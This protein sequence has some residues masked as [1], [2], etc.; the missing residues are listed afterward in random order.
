ME[1]I[2]MRKV[3]VSLCEDVLLELDRAARESQ[4]TRSVFLAQA[5]RYYL[6]ELEEERRLGFRH[7]E[8]PT[9]RDEAIRTTATKDG[10][11]RPSREGLAMTGFSI[12]GKNQLYYLKDF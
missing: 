6:K 12:E 11:L 10:L 2:D 5:I 4:T 7:C 3:N 9:C 8:I 1:R